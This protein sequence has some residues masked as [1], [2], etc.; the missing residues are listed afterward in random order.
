MRDMFSLISLINCQLNRVRAT[1]G[2]MAKRLVYQTEDLSKR[3]RGIFRICF[4]N[5]CFARHN[6]AV[7]TFF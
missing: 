2:M 1:C 6:I 7:V 4:A 5:F 3:T